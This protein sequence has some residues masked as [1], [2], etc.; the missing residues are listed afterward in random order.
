MAIY[1]I[2][3]RKEVHEVGMVGGRKYVLVHARRIDQQVVASFCP[4]EWRWWLTVEGEYQGDFKTRKEA[5]RYLF[6][7][8]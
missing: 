7:K 2:G 3:K 5:F 1:W 4:K 8:K 6:A